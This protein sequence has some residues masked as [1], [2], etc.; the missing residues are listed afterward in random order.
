MKIDL[1]DEPGLLLNSLNSW[2]EKVT[3]GSFQGT[4]G[5]SRSIELKL[6][7]LLVSQLD[8]ELVSYNAIVK[9]LEGKMS[10]VL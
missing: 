3:T 7:D 5:L 6:L 9:S 1:D 8:C 2:R 10:G 4:F